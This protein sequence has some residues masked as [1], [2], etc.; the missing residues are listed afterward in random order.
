ME[1][2][3]VENKQQQPK[4]VRRVDASYERHIIDLMSIGQCKVAIGTV[5]STATEKFSQ[6]N[7]TFCTC[8]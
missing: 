7:L 1:P 8:D 2:G 3:A 4:T 6:W 5:M